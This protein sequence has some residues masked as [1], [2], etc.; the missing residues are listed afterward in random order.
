MTRENRRLNQ[1]LLWPILTAAALIVTLG[2]AGDSVSAKPGN[3]GG[4]KPPKD[5]TPPPV[6]LNP[7][8]VY[9]AADSIYVAELAA[10]GSGLGRREFVTTGRAPSWSPDGKEILFVAD[11]GFLNRMPLFSGTGE[12]S[13]GD[14]TSLSVQG[15]A[16][17]D[18]VWSSKGWIAYLTPEGHLDVANAVDGSN[19]TRIAYD[20]S[21]SGPAL[22]PDNTKVAYGFDPDTIAIRL[23]TPQGAGFTIQNVAEFTGLTELMDMDPTD[24]LYFELG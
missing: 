21:S 13:P 12:F 24:G 6:D 4:G 18:S 22:S 5:D 20:V 19:A 11:D 10:D 2:L 9:G 3:G 14:P 8:F 17:G 1:T 7:V 23:V 16:Y 15:A